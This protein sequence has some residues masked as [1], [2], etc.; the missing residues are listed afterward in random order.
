[1]ASESALIKYEFDHAPASLDVKRRTESVSGLSSFAIAFSYRSWKRNI[2]LDAV[3]VDQPRSS[4]VKGPSHI[5]GVFK[6]VILDDET[7]AQL[8]K[9]GVGDVG[10]P[11]CRER[12]K[13][14]P[15]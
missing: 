7:V 3:R 5:E 10:D 13:T 12:A 2:V 11:L 6:E 8:E 14:E 15:P 9:D 1:M 4:R